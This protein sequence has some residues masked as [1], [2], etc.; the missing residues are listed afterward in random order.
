MKHFVTGALAL[1]ILWLVVEV[2]RAM[3]HIGRD[4]HHVH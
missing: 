3:K 4:E 1:L 2:T